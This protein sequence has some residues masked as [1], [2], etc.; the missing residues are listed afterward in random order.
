MGRRGGR[1]SREGGDGVGVVPLLQQRGSQHVEEADVG[2]EEAE[3]CVRGRDHTDEPF[4]PHP[5]LGR[6]TLGAKE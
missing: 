3:G 4:A 5:H 6:V 2:G 1:K